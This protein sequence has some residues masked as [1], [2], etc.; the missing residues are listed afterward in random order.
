MRTHIYLAD[1]TAYAT[2]FSPNKADTY[3]EAYDTYIQVYIE[4]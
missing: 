4:V 1:T 2:A 3:I